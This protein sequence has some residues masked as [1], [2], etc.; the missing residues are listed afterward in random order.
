MYGQKETL[1]NV[2]DLPRNAKAGDI[3]RAYR[4]LRGEMDKAAAPADPRRMALVHEAREVLSD[5]QRRA[6]YDASLRAPKF[7]GLKTGGA[8]PTKWAAILAGLIVLAGGRLL[9][10][11]SSPPGSTSQVPKR[12]HS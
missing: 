11:F 4:R 5:P 2:L 1:Y 12:L 9:S 7:L 10:R 3:D 6:A 8:P